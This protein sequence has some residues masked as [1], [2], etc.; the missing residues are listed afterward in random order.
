MRTVFE[1]TA[2]LF[3]SLTIACGGASQTEK[4]LDLCALVSAAQTLVEVKVLSVASST[5]QQ[6]DVS[7][8]KATVGVERTIFGS[9]V[10]TEVTVLFRTSDLE[11]PSLDLV[12]GQEGYLFAAE[13][14]SEL[15]ELMQG[16]FLKSGDEVFNIGSYRSGMAEDEFLNAVTQQPPS[17]CPGQVPE[18]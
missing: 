16:W 17:A 18:P 1:A 7:Y 12:V 6:D 5:Q 2:C 3:L 9:G 10:G 13:S 8:R 4:A 11:T 14:T 15:Q